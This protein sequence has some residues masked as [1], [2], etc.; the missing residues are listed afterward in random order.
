MRHAAKSRSMTIYNR[1]NRWSYAGHW[2]RIMEAGAG[3]DNVDMVMVDGTTVR[4][5][6][7]ATTL[8]KRPAPVL[9]SLSRRVRDKNS[10]AYQSGRV[11]D[12][13]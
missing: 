1:F 13:V 8:Q 7:S 6:Y 5:H 11:A 9:R 4:A 12:P 10:C 2:D 3:A